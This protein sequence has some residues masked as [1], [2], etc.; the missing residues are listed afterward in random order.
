MGKLNIELNYDEFNLKNRDKFLFYLLLSMILSILVTFQTYPGVFDVDMYGRWDLVYTFIDGLKNNNYEVFNFWGLFSVQ[1]EVIMWIIYSINDNIGFFTLVQSFLFYFSSF[2]LI[3]KYFFSWNKFLYIILLII[4][5][6]FYCY[7]AYHTAEIASLICI[8]FLILLLFSSKT[9]RFSEWK[10]SK[11]LIYFFELFILLNFM[12]DFRKVCFSILPVIFF[13]I[14][15]TYKKHNQKSLLKIQILAIC[16]SMLFVL[17]IPKS[18]T[19]KS[20]QIGPTWDVL[21]TIQQMPKEKQNEYIDYFDDI[22]KPGD[23]K[24][25]LEVNNDISADSWLWSIFQSGVICHPDN[26][27]KV[28]EKYINIILKEPKYFI[29]AQINKIGY[30]LGIKQPLMYELYN[31]PEERMKDFGMVD[32]FK[33]ESIINRFNLFIKMNPIFARPYIIFLFSIIMLLISKRFVEKEKF[34]QIS[35]IYAIALFLEL[36]L[37]INTPAQFF[38][39]FFVSLYYLLIVGFS[40]G[41][42]I[43]NS[44]IKKQQK[45]SKCNFVSERK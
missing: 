3:D 16:F 4:C 10:I 9:K 6:I 28:R 24:K 30:T 32:N 42:E 5:P 39:Y 20:G 2:L 26:S 15:I 45:D 8:N 40:C 33:R 35:I 17:S 19:L 29:K 14:Y 21:S 36:A 1:Y 22:V 7:S 31:N 18:L 25:A 37:I 34:Y 44:I 13:V 41:F 43:I 27:S 38:R 12:L 11:K 23:T